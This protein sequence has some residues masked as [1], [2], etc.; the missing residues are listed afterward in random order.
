MNE[1]TINYD[2]DARHSQNI[3]YSTVSKPGEYYILLNEDTVGSVL[4][5]KTVTTISSETFK[6]YTDISCTTNNDFPPVDTTF[7]D[8][9][10]TAT[11]PF[12]GIDISFLSWGNNTT[13]YPLPQS[14]WTPGTGIDGSLNLDI[15]GIDNNNYINIDIVDI[16]DSSGSINDI[17]I[18]VPG[19]YKIKFGS[20]YPYLLKPGLNNVPLDYEP[21]L[22]NEDIT[23]KG[24]IREASQKDISLNPI[25]NSYSIK[26]Y[27]DYGNIVVKIVNSNTDPIYLNA[28][29]LD[30]TLTLK[31]DSGSL[32]LD[33]ISFVNGTHELKIKTNDFGY[34]I[35]DTDFNVDKTKLPLENLKLEF[36]GPNYLENLPYSYSSFNII[37]TNWNPN[38]TNNESNISFKDNNNIILDLPEEFKI[39]NKKNASDI[40]WENNENVNNHTGEGRDRT[41]TWNTVSNDKKAFAIV[42]KID[43]GKFTYNNVDVKYGIRTVEQTYID[44]RNSNSN[45]VLA[46]IKSHQDNEDLKTSFRNFLV[47]NNISRQKYASSEYFIAGKINDGPGSTKFWHWDRNDD[48]RVSSGLYEESV[49][50]ASKLKSYVLWIDR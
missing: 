7:N 31:K 19:E 46:T 2:A 17:S 3:N 9:R 8:I 49:N 18:N 43:S 38:F 29:E 30:V 36:T 26:K 15:S 41:F 33:D 32:S 45:E 39:F 35:F 21:G 10:I 1:I 5:N 20:E 16:L 13:T 27:L 42:Q 14:T 22:L 48:Y 25:L 40:Y 34:G 47:D 37:Y 50:D 11:T 23:I 44:H 12:K 28:P 24:E 4:Y 6:V